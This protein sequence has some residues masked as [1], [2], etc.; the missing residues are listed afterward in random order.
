M[1]RTNWYKV[2]TVIF[3][4]CFVSLVFPRLTPSSKFEPHSSQLCVVYSHQPL[5]T[6]LFSEFL[7]ITS[8]IQLH[9]NF[10]ARRSYREAS[11]STILNAHVSNSTPT[12]HKC[13]FK[14]YHS[15]F[16]TL[17]LKRSCH[18]WTW[19]CYLLDSFIP[20]RPLILCENWFVFLTFHHHTHRAPLFFINIDDNNLFFVVFQLFHSI[21]HAC[22]IDKTQP[23]HQRERKSGRRRVSSASWNVPDVHP[24]Y[25]GCNVV[26]LLT[27]WLIMWLIMWLFWRLRPVVICIV[28]M[29]FHSEQYFSW[30]AWAFRN[31]WLTWCWWSNAANVGYAIDEINGS[32]S[33]GGQR[34]EAV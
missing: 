22:A 20:N 19:S 13:S 33:P 1:E 25:A 10:L 17:N 27:V 34:L 2:L 29:I 28:K 11:K 32:R 24:G 30:A 15:A 3:S 6:K 18:L 8:D 4:V 9:V 23:R 12:N 16:R 14:A 7:L 26:E 31:V 21:E 5:F